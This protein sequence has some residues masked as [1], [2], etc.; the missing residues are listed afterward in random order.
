MEVSGTDVDMDVNVA[1]LMLDVMQQ[2]LT[3]ARPGDEAVALAWLLVGAGAPCGL[4]TTSAPGFRSPG[5]YG[6]VQR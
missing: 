6:M 1:S 3:F 5:R 4:A 2:D